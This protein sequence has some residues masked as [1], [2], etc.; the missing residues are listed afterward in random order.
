[1][2]CDTGATTKVIRGGSSLT[3]V[4]SDAFAHLNPDAADEQR[5]ADGTLTDL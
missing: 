5:S 3:A 1:V 4:L 2:L